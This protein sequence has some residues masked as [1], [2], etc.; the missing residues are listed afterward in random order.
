[1]LVEAFSEHAD[2]DNVITVKSLSLTVAYTLVVRNTWWFAVDA[3]F[4]C[5]LP[6]SCCYCTL[7][8]GARYR[9]PCSDRSVS[10]VSAS[11]TCWWQTSQCG[12][13]LLCPRYRSITLSDVIS[14]LRLLNRQPQVSQPRLYAYTVT[15]IRVKILT[16]T[17]ALTVTPDHR[18]EF[19]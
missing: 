8:A 7:V 18:R 5:T 14:S 1:V 16:L 10:C 11:C 2:N 17:R 15:D 3:V 4:W 12:S 9:W 19:L 6:A 13:V